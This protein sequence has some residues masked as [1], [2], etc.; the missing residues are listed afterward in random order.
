MRSID[1]VRRRQQWQ[2]RMDRTATAMVAVLALVAGL[3]LLP[4]PWQQRLLSWGCRGVTFGVTDCVARLY[5]P[6]VAAIRATP[7]CAVDQVIEQI[8][9]TV[10]RQV[11]AFAG[12][13]QIER[14]VER[15]GDIRL[16]AVPE[17][18]ADGPVDGWAAEQW[19]AAT[20][21]PGVTMPLSAQWRFPGGAGERDIVAALQQQHADQYQ[22]LSAIAAFLPQT[23]ATARQE[24]VRP[25][26]W[27]SQSD[28]NDLGGMTSPREVAELELGEVRIDGSAATVL[29]DGVEGQTMT[30]IPLAGLTSQG[31]EVQ[32]ILRWARSV[33]G[34]ATDLAATVV[35]DS[36]SGATA[37]HLMLPL[38]AGDSAA[39][40]EWLEH[41]DGPR[42]DL[43]MLLA[44]SGP[45]GQFEQLVAAAGTV[46]VE[47][48]T[49]DRAPYMA[50]AWQHMSR[51]RRPYGEL[52]TERVS[53]ILIRPQPSGME[54]AQQEVRC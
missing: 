7:Q 52:P 46:A 50:T 2:E 30:T 48:F 51:N 21:L 44:D 8:A 17:V 54:R 37:L 5:Q 9:P 41:D 28:L 40:E 32:G 29:Q 34:V 39:V 26:G 19:P 3:T 15:T 18:G 53:T 6:P 13:G 20:I 47:E 31:G 42:L 33:D 36:P 25:S 45:E 24:A 23:S 38:A 10:E 43:T 49:T 22:R 12:G 4:Q 16:V 14:W 27:L 35:W 1:R 11:I